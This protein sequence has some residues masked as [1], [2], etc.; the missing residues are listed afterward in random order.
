MASGIQ[1]ILYVIPNHPSCT[2]VTDIAYRLQAMILVEDVTRIAPQNRPAWLN[3]V[4]IL[5]HVVEQVPISGPENVHNILYQMLMQFSP[6][7]LATKTDHNQFFSPWMVQNFQLRRRNPALLAGPAAQSDEQFF[8]G[9]QQRSEMNFTPYQ[10]MPN[11]SRKT[12]G[13]GKHNCRV[14]RFT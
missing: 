11:A 8:K 14:V 1:Y 4:P 9:F 7:S 3:T 6:N 10:T 2:P 5:I 13:T 12:F